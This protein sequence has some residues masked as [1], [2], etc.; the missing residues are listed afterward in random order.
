MLAKFRTLRMKLGLTA[1]GGLAV[2]IAM[3]GILAYTASTSEEIVNA[4]RASQQ[5][6]KGFTRLQERLDHFHKAT[7]YTPPENEVPQGMSREQ[8]DQRRREAVKT[9]AAFVAALEAI[10]TL[11]ITDP[12][13]QPARAEK[14]LRAGYATLK[15]FDNR[16]DKV[17][18]VDKVWREKGQQ[19]AVNESLRLYAD[20]Y[21]L[22][23]LTQQEITAED[24]SLEDATQRYESFRSAVIPGALA[25]LILAILGYGMLL[26]LVWRRL[27]PGLKQLESGA[28][29]FGAGQM[30][31]RINLRGHDELSRLGRAFDDMAQQLAI[32]Q[33]SLQEFALRQEAVVHER[34]RELEAA[35]AALEEADERRR[36]FFADIS[37]ELRTPLTII[38][39]EAQIA[40][41]SLD[42]GPV[43]AVPVLERI[44]SQTHSLSR[45]VGD[46]FLIARAEAGGLALHRQPFAL[47]SLVQDLVQD[48]STL[49]S[50]VGARVVADGEGPITA[51]ADPD[52][53][54]QMLMALMDNA[55]RHTTPNVVISLTAK[56][57]GDWAVVTVSDNGPGFDPSLADDL[58]SRFR[59]GKSKSDG[60]G[61]GLTVVRVL[62]EAQGGTAELTNDPEGGAVVIVRLPISLEGTSAEGADVIAA[63]G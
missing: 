56:R 60:A 58:F 46:L 34:T 40:L 31:H 33:Q 23:E 47:H 1:A 26:A 5:R 3:S 45:L 11:P 36:A 42:K 12:A 61:L 4:T 14:I 55:L 53:V 59:R 13:T 24:K 43:D 35:N 28:K 62:A 39:G 44:L 19:A 54:R 18:K 9:R 48:F 10:K 30:N 50:E 49:A 20:F 51:Y 32:K 63:A 41:R 27:S 25:C 2:V 17:A 29:A 37:H 8:S 57:E 15:V 22:R 6:M 21:K 52:R 7:I 16:K 38:R